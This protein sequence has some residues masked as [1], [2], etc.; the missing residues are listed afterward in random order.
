MHDRR[1]RYRRDYWSNSASATFAAS[2]GMLKLDQPSTFTGEIFGFTGNGTLA[3]SD[4]IDLKGINDSTVHDSYAN[5]VLTVTD[6][7][8]TVHLSF[9]GSYVVGN[10]EFA[11]DGSGGTIVYDPPVPNSSVS[12]TSATV[13]TDHRN[14]AFVF[15]PNMGANGTN[16][17]SETNAVFF[18]H[19]AFDVPALTATHDLHD[20][21]IAVNAAH[22]WITFHAS[23]AAQQHHHGFLV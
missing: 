11:S 10:F 7:T 6:G 18:D 22:D 19:A 14:D 17:T 8:N 23:A 21:L 16:H 13:A 1:R 9:S 15:H 2:T 5:G 20:T 12:G 3:G 4:Q